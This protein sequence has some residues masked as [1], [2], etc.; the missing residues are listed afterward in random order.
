MTS[1]PE[2]PWIIS[3]AGVAGGVLLGAFL[4]GTFLAGCFGRWAALPGCCGSRGRWMGGGICG[5]GMCG[6]GGGLRG[7]VVEPR[8]LTPRIIRPARA[9]IINCL[10]MIVL[11]QRKRLR[12]QRM[13]PLSLSRNSFANETVPHLFADVEKTGGLLRSR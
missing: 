5:L 11:L 9:V 10:R 8:L 6:R 1:S 4:L 2:P 12:G 7:G 3:P 13:P